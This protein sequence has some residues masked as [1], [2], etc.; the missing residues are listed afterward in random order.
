MEMRLELENTSFVQFDLNQGE[1]DER[2]THDHFQLTVPINGTL[3]VHYND[4]NCNLDSEEGFLVSP[5]DY[6][7]HEAVGDRKE[8]LIVS[9]YEDH[10]KRVF[11]EATGRNLSAIEFCNQQTDFKLPLLTEVKKIYHAAVLEGIP[12][13]MK[14]EDEAAFTFLDTMKG[15]HS[16]Q[17]NKTHRRTITGETVR[18]IKL[19]IR[20]NSAKPL[21]LDLLAS[22]FHLSK[23]HL[24]RIYKNEE[25]CTPLEYIHQVRLDRFKILVRKNNMDITKAAFESGFQSLSTFNRSFKKRYGCPPSDH[26]LNP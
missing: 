8:I 20:N 5:G 3:D 23:Y 26:F 13:A 2:H 12:E 14:L 11:E 22:E 10:L 7:Q 19:F 18:R 25:K 1:A 4:W 15:S 17:W 21:S 16:D 24:L 6:H 9:F